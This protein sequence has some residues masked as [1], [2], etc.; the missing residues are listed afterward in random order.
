MSNM[1]GYAQ[2]SKNEQNP[3]AQEAEL[4]AAGTEGTFVD[5]G[6]T[7][8]IGGLARFTFHGSFAESPELA[9]QLE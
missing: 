9:N 6:E 5:H 7:S 2:V 3:A 1:V 4:R 8:R